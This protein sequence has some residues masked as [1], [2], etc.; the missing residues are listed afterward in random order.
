MNIPF[1]EH[2]K[3]FQDP[4][5][6]MFLLLLPRLNLQSSAELAKFVSE[7]CIMISCTSILW[8]LCGGLLSGVL[9]ADESTGPAMVSTW[10]L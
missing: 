2:E 8:I 6:I 10:I 9:A 7:C 5:L 1:F 4:S 3:I